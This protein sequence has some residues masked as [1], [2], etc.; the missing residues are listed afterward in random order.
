MTV[1]ISTEREHLFTEHT[2]VEGEIKFSAVTFVE[3]ETYL[4]VDDKF[5]LPIYDMPELI[6]DIAKLFQAVKEGSSG[7][8]LKNLRFGVVHSPEL[9]EDVNLA[10][11]VLKRGAGTLSPESTPFSGIR[12]FKPTLRE[13]LRDPLAPDYSV[14]V[15][16]QLMDNIFEIIPSSKNYPNADA[17]AYL[18]EDMMEYFQPI[19]KQRGITQMRYMMREED[20]Y[21]VGS[22]N[23]LHKCPMV[24]YVRTQ[25]LKLVYEKDLELLNIEV[26]ISTPSS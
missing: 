9:L 13:T 6:K 1:P 19:F 5:K 17:G 2:P 15:Y 21:N 25:K 16:T 10:F 20:R 7:E 14:H 26:D 12:A 18:V 11:R 24:Y 8:L 4:E 22:D 3:E 23:A